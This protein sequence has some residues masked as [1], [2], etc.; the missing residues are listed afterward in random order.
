MNNN[1]V[2]ALFSIADAETSGAYMIIN[3]ICFTAASSNLKKHAVWV[4]FCFS[5]DLS[6]SLEKHSGEKKA[7]ENKYTFW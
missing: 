4:E 5:N 1:L 7:I 3:E 6:E 2:L